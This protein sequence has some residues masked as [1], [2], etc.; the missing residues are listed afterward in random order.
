VRQAPAK[1]HALIEADEYQPPFTTLNEAAHSIGYFDVD[2]DA[3]GEFRTVM[4]VVEFDH[5]YCVPLFLAIA[6][7]YAGDAPMALGLDPNGVSAVS[8]AGVRITGGR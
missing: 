6:D 4:T 2:A 5:R 8:I 1:P 7:A 3:D